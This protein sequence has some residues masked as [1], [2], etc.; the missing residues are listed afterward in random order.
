MR[1]VLGLL[2][3]AGLA[4]GAPATDLAR[5]IRENQLDRDA[6]YRI[7]DFTLFKEDIRI[8]LNDGYLIFSKPV[9]GQPVAALF[10]ADVE[11]GGAEV[12]LRPPNAAER[13]A[14]ASYIDSPNLDER[15]ESAMFFFTGEVYQ[16]LM[17]QLPNNP[18]NRR[19]PEI[20]A[21]L[22]EKWNPVLRGLTPEYD[23]RIA[24]DL[25][26]TTWR[27]PDFFSAAIR[28]VKLGTFDVFYDPDNSDQVAAGQYV[29]RDN[30]WYFD[31][32][33]HFPA[34][35]GR[36]AAQRPP[37]RLDLSGFRIDATVDS[38]LVLSAVT[39]VKVKTVA[40]GLIAVPF[41]IAGQMAI[42]E[43]KVDGA[44][45]EFLQREESA[46]SAVTSGENSLFLVIPPAPLRSGVEYEFEF[47]HSGKVILDGGDHVY[48]VAARGNWYPNLG[49]QLTTFD[50]TFHYPRGL[51]L[52]TP[53]EVLED[54]V[55]GQWRITR[56]R[57]ADPIRL[58]GFNLGDYVHSRVSRGQFVV[59]VCANRSVELQLRP[60]PDTTAV[61]APVPIL[62]RTL[63]NTPPPDF[64]PPRTP[65]PLARLEQ[66]ASDIGG[67]VEFM[68]SKFGPP[69][70]RYLTVSPIPGNFGQGY[71]GLIYLSTK[72]Y[73]AAP[74]L[75]A[76]QV[77]TTFF[78]ELLALHET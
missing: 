11:N 32:W 68:A 58:A 14:L 64:S 41:N 18:A 35:Q 34:R 39:R 66:L 16:Q 51:E 71:P 38:S 50:L 15:F 57:P 70:L 62:R 23:L 52:V 61:P 74:A 1:G 77:Q 4:L 31:T 22:E 26:N 30:R 2:C 29:T 53:G 12:I 59:D 67:M 27:K 28:G 47:H 9:A 60:R 63:R 13:H 24:M 5:A 46:R 25:L 49:P 36:N 73:L 3:F 6:C 55:D 42:S 78:D 65:D 19:A 44:P 48:Y 10:T 72:S 43:V 75:H 45:G 69:A 54:R 33:M 56:R 40:D 76:D 8:Y 17:D 21:L 20:G 37:L 7:R